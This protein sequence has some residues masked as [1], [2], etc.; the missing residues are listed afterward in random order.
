MTGIVIFAFAH[1]G[2]FDVDLMSRRVQF[3]QFIL[4]S[5]LCALS[6]FIFYSPKDI[7]DR[8]MILRQCIHFCFMLGGTLALSLFWRWILPTPQQIV[9][10]IVGV[11]I[12]YA[13][14]F[15]AIMIEN[16]RTADRLNQAIQR[17][18]CRRK[19]DA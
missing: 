6:M 13:L 7:S 14:V 11:V 2:I 1:M 17:R 9:F 8:A 18:K 5:F 3:G 15:A 4:F 12:V 19:P 10:M 16:R